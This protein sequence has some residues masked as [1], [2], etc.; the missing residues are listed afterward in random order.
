MCI[1][2]SGHSHEHQTGESHDPNGVSWSIDEH[3]SSDEWQMLVNTAVANG[4]NCSRCGKG[5]DGLLLCKF[6]G[7]PKESCIF[8]HP[9]ED[10]KLK[11]KGFSTARPFVKSARP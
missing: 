7:G 2:D 6:L 8:K 4:Q 10:Y 1:R 9:E 3:V 11:G 5:P